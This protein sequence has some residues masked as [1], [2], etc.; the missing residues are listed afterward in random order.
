VVTRSV[1]APPRGAKL[2]GGAVPTPSPRDPAEGSRGEHGKGSPGA[3]R[4]DPTAGSSG[5][6][7]GEDPTPP[8]SDIEVEEGEGSSSRKRKSQ[9]T[10]DC[11]VVLAPLPIPKQANGKGKAKKK[12]K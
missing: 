1:T 12:K 6:F 9:E 4:G 8:T 2:S 11:S 5:R 3:C 10:R 7:W